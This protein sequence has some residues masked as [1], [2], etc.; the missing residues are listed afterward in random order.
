MLIFITGYM[1]AGKT[2]LGKA[3]AEQLQFNFIDLD[4]VI[5]SAT[6]FSIETYFEKFGEKPFREKEREILLS[7]LDEKKTVIATGGGTPCYSD[8]MALMN[9]MGITVFL[10]TKVEAI[11]ER[12]A[13]NTDRRPLLKNFPAG[14]LHFFIRDHLE[15]RR[16]YYDEAVIR[17]EGEKADLDKLIGY[18]R[19][20]L[21]LSY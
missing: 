20:S 4:T 1:G 8:N 21:P 16:K 13:G 6:G 17:V 7:L 2:T 15:S 12:L 11:L 9:Q 18:V 14:K 10:D 19:S 5:E 3:L